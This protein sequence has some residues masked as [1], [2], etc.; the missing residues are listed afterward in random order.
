METSGQGDNKFKTFYNEDHVMQRL[1]EIKHALLKKGRITDEE[2]PV[3]LFFILTCK[4]RK[5]VD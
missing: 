3:K 5:S 1:H 2:F 4:E